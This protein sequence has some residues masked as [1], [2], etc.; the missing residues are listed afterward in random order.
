MERYQ[1]PFLT[2]TGSGEQLGASER[3]GLELLGDG[4][5]LSALRRRGDRLEARIVCERP[6]PCQAVLI[7][8]G[9]E[10]HLDLRPWEIRTVALR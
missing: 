1:H 8:H 3:A 4:A 5:V 2:A 10:I 6:E 7:L 9:E